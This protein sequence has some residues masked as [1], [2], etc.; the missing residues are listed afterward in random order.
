MRNFAVLT[1]SVFLA[2]PLFGQDAKH[3]K[4]EA[5]LAG[6]L[7][8]CPDSVIRLQ[9]LDTPGPKNFRSFKVTQTSSDEN[10]GTS[11]WGLVSDKTGQVLIGPV[12]TLGGEGSV[13]LRIGTRLAKMM[14][15]PVRVSIHDEKLPDGLK[16]VRVAADSKEGS[17]SF[18]TF[19]DS[20]EGFLVIGRRGNIANHAGKDLDNGLGVG[21]AATRGPVGASI[22]IL[23]LS[24]FQCPTC[25]R[26]HEF[27]EPLIEQYGDRVR[28]SRLDMPLVFGHDWSLRA[29]LGARA[30]QKVAP[31]KY[32]EYVDYIFT[33]QQVINA[34]VIDSVV[35]DFCSMHDIPWSKVQPIYSSTKESKAL[36][37]QVGRAFGNGIFS[38][39]TFMV[40]GTPVFFGHGGTHLEDYLR[41]L[42]RSA[43]GTKSG[44]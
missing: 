36:L 12:F 34:D 40:N 43:P 29:S 17:I 39:P 15:M 3:P 16:I 44:K 25:K 10:C 33:N 24:D 22:Q 41:R 30:I 5:Y 19:M 20:T 18:D 27:I 38:T 32:W 42:M 14:G 11:T 31:D 9:E 28:Y 23:E 4:L 1:L 8:V 7:N 35:R 13:E 6:A 37:E 26:A 21:S 2:L